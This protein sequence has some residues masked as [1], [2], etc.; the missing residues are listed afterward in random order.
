MSE[1]KQG[2]KRLPGEKTSRRLAFYD[3]DRGMAL[4]QELARQDGCASVALM[5]RLIRKEAAA[6]GIESPSVIRDPERC[7]GDPI[8]AGTRTAVHDVVAT[9]RIY[10]GDL[11]EVQAELPHLSMEQIRAALAWYAEHT[12]EIDE[13][14]RQVHEDYAQ[15]LA[16]APVA[17]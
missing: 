3:D 7:A 4:L 1:M 17:R 2:P 13:I 15:G 10:S 9:A 11:G 5:R 14:L 6:R 8:L 12:A 16:S